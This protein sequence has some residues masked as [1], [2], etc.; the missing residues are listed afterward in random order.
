MLEKQHKKLG[1]GKTFLSLKNDIVNLIR[2]K[3]FKIAKIGNTR[4][5][6]LTKIFEVGKIVPEIWRRRNFS[7]SKKQCKTFGVGETFKV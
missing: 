3:I 1:V 4:S 5:L 6:M 7:K 2:E